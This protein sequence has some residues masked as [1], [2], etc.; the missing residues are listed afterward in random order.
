MSDDYELAKEMRDAEIA[1][2]GECIILA[3][4]AICDRL[5]ISLDE[6]EQGLT[7]LAQRMIDEFVE[8]QLA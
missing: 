1:G 5:D 7:P 6:T 8:H 4:N 3:Q 2:D